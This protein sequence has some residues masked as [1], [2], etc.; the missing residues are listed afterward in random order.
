MSTLPTYPALTAC[1]SHV[2]D[3]AVPMQSRTQE[4]GPFYSG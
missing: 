3:P 4:K 2:H 1:D